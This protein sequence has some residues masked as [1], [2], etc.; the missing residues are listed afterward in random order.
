MGYLGS[1]DRF[2]LLTSAILDPPHWGLNPVNGK[3]ELTGIK[4]SSLRVFISLLPRNSLCLYG[5]QRPI[6]HWALNG[7]AIGGH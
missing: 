6:R 5:K 7:I 3:V 4:Y 1:L 2:D